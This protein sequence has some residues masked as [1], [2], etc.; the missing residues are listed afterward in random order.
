[1]KIKNIYLPALILMAA[2]LMS[3][4]GA[5]PSAFPTLPA[6]P[7]PT[8]SQKSLLPTAQPPQPTSTPEPTPLPVDAGTIPDQPDANVV[9]VRAVLAEDDSWTFHVTV[10][11]PDT[12]WDN[13]TDGWN[14]VTPEGTVLKVT[15][16]D[17]FTRLLLH[18]HENEQPFTRSQ[19]GIF[20]PTGITQVSIRAHDI[21]NGFGGLEVTVDLEKDSGPGYEVER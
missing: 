16:G 6:P 12:G 9:H 2:S 5:N 18:P 11:H 7:D 13:Y 15:P 17:P 4:C 14:V 19:S 3:A 21:V 10:E 8:P 20:I 1:M